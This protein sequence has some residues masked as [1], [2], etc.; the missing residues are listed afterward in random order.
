MKQNDL[1]INLKHL[2]GILCVFF[3]YAK[4]YYTYYSNNLHFPLLRFQLGYVN[5]LPFI[6]LVTDTIL[7]Y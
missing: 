2:L 6:L 5:Y 4:L 7:Y 3:N 1:W